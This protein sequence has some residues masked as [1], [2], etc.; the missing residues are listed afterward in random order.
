MS[1]KLPTISQFCVLIAKYSVLMAKY[2]RNWE[3]FNG[4]VQCFSFRRRSTNPQNMHFVVKDLCTE[5]SGTVEY[6]ISF[7]TFYLKMYRSSRRVVRSG[8]GGGGWKNLC[9]KIGYGPGTPSWVFHL[10]KKMGYSSAM[11]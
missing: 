7:Q 6:R 11:Y 9:I 3:F 2:I 1:T 5:L 10:C 8:G 4:N